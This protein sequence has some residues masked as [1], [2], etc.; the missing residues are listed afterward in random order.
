ME[1]HYNTGQR[2]RRNK[3]SPHFELRFCRI[4]SN[5]NVECKM[6]LM[7]LTRRV[8][9]KFLLST[10]FFSV[11]F[12]F[13]LQQLS[14]LR[15]SKSFV[16]QFQDFLLEIARNFFSI[17]LETKNYQIY[18][19]PWKYLQEIFHKSSNSSF[20]N[21]NWFFFFTLYKFYFFPCSST[22]FN[23]FFIQFA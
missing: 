9:I 15:S 2:K 10:I 12:P 21:K 13:T 23:V 8:T 5:V 4:E 19:I 18:W 7:L 11:R 3:T 14:L 1:F 22:I 20:S 16:F 6:Q 17:A